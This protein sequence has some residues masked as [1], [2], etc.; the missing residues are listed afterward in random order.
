MDKYLAEVY[1]KLLVKITLYYAASTIKNT[2]NTYL[3]ASFKQIIQTLKI[4]HFDKERMIGE[5]GLL[6][7][8][9]V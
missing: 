4:K 1:I 2:A 9:K 5:E 6:L 3:K 7:R 8:E